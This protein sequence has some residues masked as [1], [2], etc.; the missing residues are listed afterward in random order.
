MLEIILATALLIN[1]G[2]VNSS[3]QDG[4]GRREAR[5]LEQTAEMSRDEQ[6][7]LYL[8]SR[9]SR[10]SSA[11]R[12]SEEARVT[13]LVEDPAIRNQFTEIHES[14]FQGALTEWSPQEPLFRNVKELIQLKIM[15]ARN[16]HFRGLPATRA[17][18]HQE[19][20][21]IQALRRQ[22]REQ[23]LFVGREV[24]YA[25]SGDRRK[26]GSKYRHV[27]GH[28]PTQAHVRQQAER[29]TFYRQ[30]DPWSSLDFGQQ[31]EAAQDLTLLFEGHGREKALKLEGALSFADLGRTLRA[32]EG[33]GTSILLLDA[34]Q[35]HNYSRRLL[36]FLSQVAGTAMPVIITPEEYGQDFIKSAYGDRFLSDDL[37]LGQIHVK[38]GHLMED[39]SITTSVYVPDQ[40]NLPT[41]IL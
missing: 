11:K 33:R 35:S 19:Y 1:G 38:M 30:G 20:E 31:V 40:D 25:A 18:M 8:G 34:C 10:T 22:Y 36:D 15:I 7:A 4:K 27:F 9:Q 24:I 26:V 6:L 21:R 5:L 12:Y 13:R 41:Q 2:V 3:T 39:S 23:S 37:K 16:L 17:A 14:W 29:F 32:R 28:Q